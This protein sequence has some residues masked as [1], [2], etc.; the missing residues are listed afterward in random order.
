MFNNDPDLLKKIMTGDESCVIGYDIET[1]VQLFCKSI[2]GPL[3]EAKTRIHKQRSFSG[4]IKLII[5]QIRH[6]LM[7]YHSRNKN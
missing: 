4:R 2:A 1:K 5:D 6:Q 3:S 7:S